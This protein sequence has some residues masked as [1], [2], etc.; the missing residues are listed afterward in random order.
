MFVAIVVGLMLVA[1]VALTGGMWLYMRW[2]Q[3]RVIPVI[4]NILIF[5]FVASCALETVAVWPVLFP[6]GLGGGSH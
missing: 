6:H 1:N 4:R 5:T 2:R 3:G